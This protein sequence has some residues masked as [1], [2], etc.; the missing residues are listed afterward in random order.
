MFKTRALAGAALIAGLS[1][2]GMLVPAAAN[3]AAPAPQKTESIQELRAI[4]SQADTSALAAYPACNDSFNVVVKGSSTNTAR[5]PVYSVA[6][7]S[8]T[9]YNCIME[10]GNSG[11]G[12]RTLQTAL[13]ACYGKGL[14]VDGVFGNGTYNALLQ[15]QRQVGVSIDGVY[16][17]GTRNAMQWRAGDGVCRP[18]N[19]YGGF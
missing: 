15:V 17:P 14:A 18:G 5:I 3:A 13:N 9:T 4:A 16:G 11:Q 2:A 7:G 6:A 1:L 19:Q 12:V 10:R 8:G